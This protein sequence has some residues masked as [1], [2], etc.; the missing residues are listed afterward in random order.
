MKISYKLGLPQKSSVLMRV[1]NT[2]GEE[3]KMVVDEELVAGWYLLK[4]TEK[5]L[6]AGTYFCQVKTDVG[7]EVVKMIVK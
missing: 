6:P 7:A 4:F 3:L 5:K 1:L 2:K